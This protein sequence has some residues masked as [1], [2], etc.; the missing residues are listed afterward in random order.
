[1]ATYSAADQIN[2]ALRLLGVLAEG[3]TP[4]AAHTSTLPSQKTPSRLAERGNNVLSR[5]IK[6][7]HS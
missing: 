2:R 6:P 4:A 1:M 7:V 3:E 5:S